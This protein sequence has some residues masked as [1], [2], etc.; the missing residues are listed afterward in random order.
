[1][2]LKNG[3]TR[4]RVASVNRLPKGPY[5]EKMSGMSAS[6]EQTGD[7]H[8][9][10]GR[11][12]IA[13]D[14]PA[15]SGKTTVAARL[16]DRLGAVFLDTG[17]L[18]RAATLLA[19]RSNLT[20]DDDHVIGA[21]ITAGEIAIAPPSV[22]DGR[23]SDVFIGG[24]D[25]TPLL[26]TAEIDQNVSAFSALPA[27]RTAL[28]PMQREFARDQRVIMVGRDIATVVFPGAGVQIYLDAS[29]SER[30]RRRWLE[31]NAD[32]DGPDLANVEADLIRRDKIDSSREAS[33][34]AMA[35]GA[36]HVHTDGKSIDE[37]VDE[38]AALVNEASA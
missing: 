22:R 13:I 4:T 36:L 16:A 5:P 28:L 30:A 9:V 24:A 21:R 27:L 23:T 14:G 32:G 37:V 11:N 8:L 6:P 10:N 38:I 7:Q 2:T 25:V 1:M 15:G 18:Y 33:P 29:A 26:R 3:K 34:L 19:L 20:T 31:L 12:V 17:L 35:D